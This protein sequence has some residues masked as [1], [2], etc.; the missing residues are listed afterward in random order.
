MK[1]D[2]WTLGLQVVNALVLIWLLSRF[3]FRPV[4]DMLAARQKA[5]GQAIADAQA[6]KAAADS[7]KAKAEIEAADIAAHR[8]EALKA[9]EAEA[10]N[11]KAAL[12]AA[13]RA[14]AEKL[15]AA[16]QT[17]IDSARRTEVA[18]AADRAGKLALDIAS[19]LF[20]RLPSE[21]RIDG[22][23][24]GI[25]TGLSE[26][27]QGTRTALAASGKP[28]R[29]IVARALNAEENAACRAALAGLLGHP[30]EIDITED[31]SL[32]AGIELE[33]PDAIVRNSFRAELVRLK[34]ELIGH[35]RNLT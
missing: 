2:L 3:L 24:K 34:S 31:P 12:I 33:A 11:E 4:A 35:D 26:L 1:I 19:K 7:A 8:R 9:V 10:S 17:E 29:L 14:D 22:F 6:A 13:A 32:I 5:A 25:A 27:P 23:I 18:A 15:R 21:A 28:I 16:A 30:V 20:D